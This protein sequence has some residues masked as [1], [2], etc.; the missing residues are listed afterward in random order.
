M[1]SRNN[2]K[3]NVKY[4]YHP[5]FHRD[6]DPNMLPSLLPYLPSRNKKKKK[7][8]QQQ[9]KNGITTNKKKNVILKMN[10]AFPTN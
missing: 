9:Q 1:Q 2:E 6:S 3:V 5:N 10:L 8:Q 7:K 4:Y